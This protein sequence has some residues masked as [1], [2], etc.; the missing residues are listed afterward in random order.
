MCVREGEPQTNVIT[1]SMK[2]L[3]LEDED[4]ERALV[5][6]TIA[7]IL[8]NSY[9]RIFRLSRQREQ[10][11][12]YQELMRIMKAMKDEIASLKSVKST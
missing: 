1:F 7:S 10:N 4:S 2:E 5:R 8:T 11:E 3:K 6:H 12:K 9:S